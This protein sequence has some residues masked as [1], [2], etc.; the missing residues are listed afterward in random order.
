M[1]EFVSAVR[2]DVPEIRER[3]WYLLGTGAALPTIVNGGLGA[4]LTRVS[5][6]LYSIVWKESPGKF[7]GFRYGLGATVP[8]G[9]AGLMVAVGAYVPATFT[10]PVLL[11]TTAGIATDL[12]ALQ[13]LTLYFTFKESGTGV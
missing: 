7:V 1:S 4:T 12:L 3:I 10:L 5:A 2:A 9:L 8:A 11:Q 13:N 6:G